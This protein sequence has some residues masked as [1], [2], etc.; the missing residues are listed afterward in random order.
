[1]WKYTH[2]DELTHH[3]ILGMRWGVRRKRNASGKLAVKGEEAPKKPKKQSAKTSTEENTPSPKPVSNAELRS[4][5]ERIELEK[6]YA[7]L[8]SERKGKS[9]VAKGSKFVGDIIVDS[10]KKALTSYSAA[11]INKGLQ[12]VYSTKTP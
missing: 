7:T 5:V 10:S 3:G 9:A 2:T 6:R 4:M 8:M 12:R 11:L 1:M